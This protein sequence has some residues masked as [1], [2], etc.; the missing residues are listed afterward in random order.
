MVPTT[1]NTYQ[2]MLRMSLNRQ[3][4]HDFMVHKYQ[5]VKNKSEGSVMFSYN[6]NLEWLSSLKLTVLLYI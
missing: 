5:H 6:R 2:I 1:G 3:E 4:I